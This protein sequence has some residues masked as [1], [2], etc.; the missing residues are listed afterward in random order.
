MGLNYKIGS[1]IVAFKIKS[2]YEISASYFT[3]E[4]KESKTNDQNRLKFS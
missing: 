4:I 3:F 1:K 2:L